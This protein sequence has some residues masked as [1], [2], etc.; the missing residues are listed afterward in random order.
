MAEELGKSAIGVT[1]TP[2]L[3]HGHAF[4]TGMK[5][6]PKDLEIRFVGVHQQRK[7]LSHRSL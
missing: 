4:G 2:V 7:W 1:D 3:D 5:S 6:I